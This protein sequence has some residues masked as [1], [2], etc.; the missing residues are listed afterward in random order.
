MAFLSLFVSMLSDLASHGKIRIHLK[1]QED[2]H[3]DENTI[4]PAIT[5][6]SETKARDASASAS[7]LTFTSTFSN[8]ESPNSLQNKNKNKNKN[9]RLLENIRHYVLHDDLFLVQKSYFIHFYVAG[10]IC[11]LYIFIVIGHFMRPYLCQN[12]HDGKESKQLSSNYLTLTFTFTMTFTWFLQT[13]TT[14]AQSYSIEQQILSILLL[15]HLSRRCWECKYVHRYS[16]HAKMHIAGY[17][18][19]VLHYTMLPMVVFYPRLSLSLIDESQS[20]PNQCHVSL[21]DTSTLSWVTMKRWIKIK[22]WMGVILCIIGQKEQYQHHVILANLRNN[23]CNTS[24]DAARQQ[25]TDTDTTNHY[26]IPYGRWFHYIS[27]PH[28]FAEMIIYLSFAIVLDNDDE[29]AF[30]NHS[31]YKNDGMSMISHS[32]L[33][34]SKDHDNVWEAGIDALKILSKYKH[35]ALLVWVWVNLSVSAAQNHSWYK[36]MFG[37]A[38]PAQRKRLIP[39]IW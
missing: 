8:S 34:W 20:H 29:D 19:G 9:Q 3:H 12:D 18:L 36:H 37:D 39:W 17:V 22:V 27:C 6:P 21:D 28:Y 16:K 2:E 1:H 30:H 23:N 32:E 38:Y 26:Q 24:N 11:A 31:V 14:I 15:T 35:W 33:K 10:V 7:P 25:D 13:I 4:H 5:Q